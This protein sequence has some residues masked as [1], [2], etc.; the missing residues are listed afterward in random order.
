MKTSTLITLPLLL[1]HLALNACTSSAGS[2]GQLPAGGTSAPPGTPTAP[3]SS[4]GSSTASKSPSPSISP[5]PSPSKA[6]VTAEQVI[7]QRYQTDIFY[8]GGSGMGY[9]PAHDE[10]S[11]DILADSNF[12]WK[13]GLVTL[14]EVVGVDE[15]SVRLSWTLPPQELVWGA[16]VPLTL[17]GT[18]LAT[19]TAQ[20]L[21]GKVSALIDRDGIIPGAITGDAHQL[22]SV[23]IVRTSG[24]GVEKSLKVSKPLSWGA[25]SFSLIVTA[26]HASK[27][28]AYAYRYR[29]IN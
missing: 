13:E 1:S 26:T 18:L 11:K 9:V 20:P 23:E 14:K 28:V 16:T 5:Q 12:S 21:S 17:T 2:L 10:R 25:S 7:Y 15:Q 3:V 27:G 8:Y 6:P 22:G 29:R 24:I 4:P 19:N